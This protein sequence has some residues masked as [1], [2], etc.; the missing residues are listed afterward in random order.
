MNSAGVTWSAMAGT[1]IADLIEGGE[2][3]VDPRPYAPGRFGDRSAD[4]GWLQA[5]ASA[6]VSGGYR[7][8]NIL[9]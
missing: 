8:Q 6:S 5:Q 3:T 1:L 4:A 9:P 7:K 2:T